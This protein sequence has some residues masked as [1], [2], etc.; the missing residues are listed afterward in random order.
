[1]YRSSVR[2][3]STLFTIWNNASFL[4]FLSIECRKADDFSP[5]ILYAETLK[6]MYY[7]R[8]HLVLQYIKSDSSREFSFY[9]QLKT[10]RSVVLTNSANTH[11]C[12]RNKKKGLENTRQMK[13]DHIVHLL[14]FNTC[15]FLW[16]ETMKATGK[17]MRLSDRM[18]FV[19]CF[20]WLNIQS[21]WRILLLWLTLPVVQPTLITKNEIKW[22]FTQA[23]S[24]F[25]LFSIWVTDNHP[26]NICIRHF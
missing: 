12:T 5:L 9:L 6:L 19:D 4:L 15:V 16:V 23:Y 24:N 7:V 25:Q 26:K 13:L 8:T 2:H 3:Q 17:T 11:S 22:L 10:P 21:S 14:A 18:F 1:M 20:L